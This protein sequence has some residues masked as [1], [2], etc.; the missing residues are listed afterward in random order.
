MYAKQAKQANQ[1][2][3]KVSK[4][5]NQATQGESKS[6]VRAIEASLTSERPKCGLPKSS[7]AS[8]LKID[9]KTSK[10]KANKASNLA[11]KLVK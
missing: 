5:W 7:N 6:S 2:N 10:A 4:Q 11:S 8:K 1:S 9:H 3:N